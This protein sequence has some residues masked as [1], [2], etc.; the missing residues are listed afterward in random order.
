[1]AIFPEV[2]TWERNNGLY[3]AYISRYITGIRHHDSIPRESF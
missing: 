2:D 3:A 1:M